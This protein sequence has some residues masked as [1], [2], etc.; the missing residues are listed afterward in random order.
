MT[1]PELL[2]EFER[3]FR[4]DPDPWAFETSDYERRKR[5]AT[6][7]ACGPETGR[8]V[9]ELGAGNGVLAAA[10]AP[11]AT[12]LVAVEGVPAAAALAADRLASVP[13]ATVIHGLIPHDVPPGPFDLIVASEILYYLDAPSYEAALASFAQWLAPGGRLVA[14]HWRPTSEERPR[15]ADT[16]HAELGALAG[17]AVRRELVDPDYLLSVFEAAPA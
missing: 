12:Q 3:R 14:V 2:A 17:L 5:A 1:D 6:V 11:L 10:L 9:L 15:S 4:Q 16:V 7:A 8:R 13:H